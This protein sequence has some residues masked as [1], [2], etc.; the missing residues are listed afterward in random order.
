MFFF[1][2]KQE[3]KLRDV[4]K[5]Q[6][7]YIPQGHLEHSYRVVYPTHSSEE[8]FYKI[9]IILTRKARQIKFKEDGNVLNKLH[10]SGLSNLFKTKE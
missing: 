7:S 6:P 10:G 2:R 4:I 8:I 3:A 9:V 1:D 5:T